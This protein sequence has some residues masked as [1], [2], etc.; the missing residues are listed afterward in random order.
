MNNT[1]EMNKYFENKE[2][3][4]ERNVTFLGL[5]SFLAIIVTFPSDPRGLG[6]SDNQY[7]FPCSPC[8][9]ELNVL[10]MET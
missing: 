9:E 8:F 1:D 6:A 10:D 7:S 2:R 5:V 4:K 3:N